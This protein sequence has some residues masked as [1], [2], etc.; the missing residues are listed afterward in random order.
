MEDEEFE[1]WFDYHKKVVMVSKEGHWGYA[2]ESGWHLKSIQAYL[3]VAD[4]TD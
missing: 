4:W 3:A 1:W 2:E